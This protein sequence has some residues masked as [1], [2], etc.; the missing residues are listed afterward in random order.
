[1]S[2]R[3]LY[4]C[5]PKKILGKES[6]KNYYYFCTAKFAKEGKVTKQVKLAKKKLPTQV[7]LAIAMMC[8]Q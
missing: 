3:S 5:P 1:V 2:N 7:N 8:E 6:K 4:S